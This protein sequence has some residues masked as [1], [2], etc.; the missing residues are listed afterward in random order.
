MDVKEI[1]DK[2]KASLPFLNKGEQ[3]DD[4]VT[5]EHEIDVDED[6]D[7]EEEPKKKKAKSEEGEEGEEDE[8]GDEDDEEID[9]AAAK[10]SKLIKGVAAIVVAWVAIDEFVLKEEPPPPQPQVQRKRPKRKKPRKQPEPQATQVIEATPEVIQTPEVVA[11][12]EPIATPEIMETPMAIATPD[13]IM[14][15]EVVAT[16]DAPT[17]GGESDPSTNPMGGF[18]GEGG[19]QQPVDNALNNL[20]DNVQDQKL[21]DKIAP[22]KMEYIEPPDY[23]SLG[24]GLVYNC[25]GKHWACVDKR[26]YFQ[27]RDNSKWS[28]ENEKAPECVTRPVYASYEDCRTIQKFYVNTNKKIDFCE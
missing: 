12:P 21:E 22:P 17:A 13:P 4:D 23:E 11:T 3:E 20:V 19:A 15:P 7:E 24:R 27:C 1:I 18:V 26:S 14:T 8:E 10:R 25:K 9:E 16:P 5:G 2:I 6:V 28:K